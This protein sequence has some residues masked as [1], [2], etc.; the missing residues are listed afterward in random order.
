MSYKNVEERNCK[1][2]E[3]YHKN[4]EKVLSYQKEYLKN[5]FKKDVEFREKRYLRD[6][7]RRE[8]GL[9]SLVGE[10]CFL[11]ESSEDLHRH[12]PSYESTI[13]VILCRRCHNNTHQMLKAK[14][15]IIFPRFYEHKQ[16]V[17]N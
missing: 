12:H 15:D 6:R 1:A 10:S 16:L 7:S 11:C 14:K 13:F 8:Q 9:K 17:G 4:R 2:R 5:K 3:Y